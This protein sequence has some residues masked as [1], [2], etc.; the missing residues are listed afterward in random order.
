MWNTHRWQ[1]ARGMAVLQQPLHGPGSSFKGDTMNK[2]KQLMGQGKTDAIWND[3]WHT[4][5][6]NNAFLHSILAV[7]FC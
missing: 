2:L 7:E 6:F 5:T 1:Q 3:S 4:G